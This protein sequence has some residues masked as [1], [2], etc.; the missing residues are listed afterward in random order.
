MEEYKTI[1]GYDNYEVS[2]FGN[3]RNTKTKRVL[4]W[5]NIGYDGNT[6]NAVFLNRK[7]KKIHQLVANAFFR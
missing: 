1:E 3:V 5:R 4:K 6:Y 2:N 7:N